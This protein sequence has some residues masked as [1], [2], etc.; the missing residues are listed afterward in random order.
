[1]GKLTK[2]KCGDTDVCATK[3]TDTGVLG[4]D[5]LSAP[6][7][8]VDL[9]NL[10]ITFGHEKVCT[11]LADS[12]A[13]LTVSRV[14]L[15]ENTTI[16]PNSMKSAL[17][18]LKTLI[19]ED[20]VIEPF[21]IH[22]NIAISD[23][24]SVVASTWSDETN[25]EKTDGYETVDE[26][27]DMEGDWEVIDE[28]GDSD[29]ENEE[30][31]MV[32]VKDPLQDYPSF[33]ASRLVVVEEEPEQDKLEQEIKKQSQNEQSIDQ[34]SSVDHMDGV[35]ITEEPDSWTIIVKASRLTS[36]L[37]PKS[38]SN[39]PAGSSGGREDQARPYNVSCSRPNR[40]QASKGPKII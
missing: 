20:Y 11:E 25:A 28:I 30:P 3:L 12:R 14:M 35:M 26:I 38:K 17:V 31:R 22:D 2:Q 39:T 33:E 5:I 19:E 10:T 15:P 6:K 34:Q 24:L 40:Q 32:I 8:L 16:F 7:G 13:N 37:R 23:V 18:E 29:E 9:R 4:L 36:D 21:L 1:M 27:E